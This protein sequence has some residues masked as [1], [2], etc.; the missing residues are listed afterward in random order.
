M[1]APVITSPG[2]HELVKVERNYVF[3]YVA[4]CSC[5]WASSESGRDDM[6]ERYWEC[7][8][9]NDW[10]EVGP[11]VI[12]P[13]GVLYDRLRAGEI[14]VVNMRPTG[15]HRELVARCR[16]DGDFVRIDRRSDWG[17]PFKIGKKSS[18]AEVVANFEEYLAGKPELLERLPDLKGKAL[19]CWC[20]PRA[21]HGDVLKR[22]VE[23]NDKRPARP[24]S[25][26]PR[27]LASE[28]HG[29]T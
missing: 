17:N 6:A 28:D 1:T 10:E 26:P 2:P 27:P 24:D 18:R 13:P 8:A 20:A 11:L 15:P 5:G 7:H 29:A 4:I 3:N 9:I 21:C 22:W 19:A 23:R 12:E 25:P 14:I 16:A